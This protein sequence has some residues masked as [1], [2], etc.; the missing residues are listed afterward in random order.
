[1]I[2]SSKTTETKTTV[3]ATT[4]ITETKTT[5]KNFNLSLKTI[6]TWLTSIF[7]F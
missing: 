3:N 4:T 5:E 1:M 7:W 2:Y 6:L